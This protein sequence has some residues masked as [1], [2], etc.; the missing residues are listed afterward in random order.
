[1][2]TDLT[3]RATNL[4]AVL[5]STDC[6]ALRRISLGTLQHPGQ[7]ARK[8]LAGG[9]KLTA[10]HRALIEGMAA[11]IVAMTSAPRSREAALGLIG[12]MLL[13]YPMAAGSAESGKARGEAYLDA[14]DDVPP[15][16][17]AEAIRKWH[18]G[19][20]G[21]DHNYRF[22]PAP[23]ELRYAVMQILQPAKQTIAHLNALLSALTIERAMDPTPIEIAP[24]ATVPRLRAV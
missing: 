15:W 2:A 7:P 12:K 10:E 16:A 5:S 20:C 11:D 17:L 21:P 19:E 22:A 14:L 13:A 3:T 18:R 4:Q 9:L 24:V 6:V 8:Y 23:A 1:M